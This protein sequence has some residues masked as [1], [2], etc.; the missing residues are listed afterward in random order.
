MYNL[1]PSKGPE[2]EGMTTLAC[3]ALVGLSVTTAVI[4]F[5]AKGPLPGA[6]L[7][8]AMAAIVYLLSI[9]LSRFVEAYRAKAWRTAAQAAFLA[10][11]FV[12]LEANLNHIGL[13]N[14]NEAYAIAPEGYLW[15]ACWFLSVVNVFATDTYT[16]E[17][18]VEPEAAA[19]GRGEPKRLEGPQA[20]LERPKVAP[21]RT[22]DR[23]TMEAIEHVKRVVKVA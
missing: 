3:R 21:A 16:R 8:V 10:V 1:T 2:A 12:V 18:K 5:W 15:P 23:K 6:L 7:T 13:A 14:L 17:L 19:Q 4:G 11:G 9:S 22:P 20:G